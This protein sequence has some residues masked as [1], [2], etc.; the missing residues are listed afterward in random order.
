MKWNPTHRGVVVRPL[1]QAEKTAGGVFLPEQA[2]RLLEA[3]VVE[4]GPNVE[5]S[6]ARPLAVHLHGL[7]LSR[8]AA[9]ARL[10]PALSEPSL[11]ECAV[12]LYEASAERAFAGH[13][14]ELHWLPTFA[15]MAAAAIES[16]R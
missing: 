6:T 14:S 1:R 16:A 2:Q 12:R 7:N 13:Y 11:L 9:L 10:A 3:I 8:A 4:V 15:W 5:H